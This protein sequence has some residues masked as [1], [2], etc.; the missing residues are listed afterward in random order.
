MFSKY[1]TQFK[2]EFNYDINLDEIEKLLKDTKMISITEN[3]K[4]LF[5]AYYNAE[6]IG[7]L[8]KKKPNVKESPEIIE[9][10]KI[11]NI[12]MNYKQTHFPFVLFNCTMYKNKK[13]DKININE[14]SGYLILDYD[15]LSIQDMIKL[16]DALKQI[17]YVS[18]IFDSPSKNGIKVLIKINKLDKIKHDDLYFKEYFNFVKDYIKNEIFNITNINYEADISGSNINRGCYIPFD[19]TYYINKRASKLEYVKK[20]AEKIKVDNKIK[21]ENKRIFNTQDLTTLYKYVDFIESNKLA[22][23]NDY[24]SWFRIACIIKKQLGL[25][26]EGKLIFNKISSLS[27]GYAGIDVTNKKYENICNA[28]AD[29]EMSIHYLYRLIKISCDNYDELDKQLTKDEIT[30]IKNRYINIVD[31]PKIISQD[32]FRLIENEITHEMYIS[33]DGQKEIHFKIGEIGNNIR[34]HFLEKYNLDISKKCDIDYVIY[35]IPKTYINPPFEKIKE[36]S[37]KY[38]DKKS[39]EDNFKLFCDLI[40]TDTTADIDKYLLLKRFLLSVINNITYVRGIGRKCDEI[41]ILRS[42]YTAGKTDLIR[43]YLFEPII[44]YKD[45]YMF[46]ESS[47]FSTYNKDL[48][49]QDLK[50]IINYKPEISKM[51]TRDA[52]GIKSYLSIETYS[53][54]RAY[55][56]DDE[57][58]IT[59]V[60]FIGDTNNEYYLPSDSNLRR[61]LVLNI[62]DKLKFKTKDENGKIVLNKDIN[63]EQIWGYLY[64]EIKE[65]LTYDMID[66]PLF[67]TN[68]TDQIA[69]D[70]DDSIINNI[71]KKSDNRFFTIDEL[72]IYIKEKNLFLK[73]TS[74]ES[75]RIKLR[76]LGLIKIVK[77]NPKSKKTERMYPGYFDFNESLYV[78]NVKCDLFNNEIVESKK[79][80]VDFSKT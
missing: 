34:K 10:R 7:Y 26:D 17:N 6:P 42:E 66:I 9:K 15:E 31:V 76:N 55:R 65:G 35:N 23:C 70:Y 18:L 53:L 19:D 79:K 33:W 67:F 22:V 13:H 25:C 75:I 21:N 50:S 4:E 61:F 3:S 43:N 80:G 74:H 40:P 63:F 59:H 1:D 54:R 73:D 30:A 72:L 58:F 52:N 57:E 77:Y 45:E 5:N 14:Y 49:H 27:S 2:T 32:N 39:N 64:N 69:L 46:K 12:Y 29:K 28:T 38:I 68:I 44:K 41:L 47:N 51:L 8:E 56:T 36:L 37:E 48:L 60:S 11:K 78:G 24:D 62:T 16:K 20:I 71:I